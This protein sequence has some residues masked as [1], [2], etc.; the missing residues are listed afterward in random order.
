MSVYCCSQELIKF[1][2]KV[3]CAKVGSS[4]LRHVC[5]RINIPGSQLSPSSI[6]LV[7]AQAGKVTVGL[8]SHWPCVTDTV[9]YPPTGS[10]AKDRDEHPCLC[11]FVA[12]HHLPLPEDDGGGGDNRSYKTCRTPVKS[13]PP[14]NSCS[15]CHP[16][17]SVRSLNENFIGYYYY[18]YYCARLSVCL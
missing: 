5:Y 15:S 13:L 12:W 9:V 3:R 6:N 14:T 8:A 18:Y 17:N 4:E 10:T 1:S 2:T 16:T 11:P 7:P